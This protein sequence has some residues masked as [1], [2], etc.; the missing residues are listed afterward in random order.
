M[1]PRWMCNAGMELNR[2]VAGEILVQVVF[3][4]ILCEIDNFDQILCELS[5]LDT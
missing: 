4:G 1:L 5:M 2:V 3:V